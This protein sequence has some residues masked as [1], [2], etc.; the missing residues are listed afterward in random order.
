MFFPIALSIGF[1]GGAFLG[2]F[3]ARRGITADNALLQR[4]KQVYLTGAI[5]LAV[6]GSQAG[7]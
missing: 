1:I 7:E 2:Q 5:S 6:R 4:Q 3:L